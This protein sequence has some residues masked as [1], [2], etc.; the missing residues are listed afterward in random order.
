MS[1][2]D[3][4]AR[5]A[6]RFGADG[7]HI[8]FYDDNGPVPEGVIGELAV[9]GPAVSPGYHNPSGRDDLAKTHIGGRLHSGDLGFRSSDGHIH[10]TGR[11]RDMII[12]GGYNV[13]PREVEESIAD[14]DGVAEVVVVGLPDSLWG[15][16]IVAGYTTTPDATVTDDDVRA[17]SRR[18]LPDFKRP[19]AVHR[20]RS[21]PLTA[22]GKADRV[23]AATLLASYD[24]K[25]SGTTSSAKTEL[26]I[27]RKGA[28]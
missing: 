26:A 13:Y 6:D 7:V 5:A 8:D 20:L 16:R 25:P 3:V 9:S 1:L 24:Q 14:I 17:H 15:Q 11:S 12:T 4:V 21:L 28:P 10:L 19:K 2:S 27:T 23:R 22:L 18:L